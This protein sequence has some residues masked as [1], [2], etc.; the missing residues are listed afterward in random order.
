MSQELK[1]LLNVY[2]FSRDALH[3]HVH[4]MPADEISRL[5][6]LQ[7]RTFREILAYKSEHPS[8]T[9]A[10]IRLAMEHIGEMSADTREGATMREASQVQ[11]ARLEQ[12]L[13]DKQRVRAKAEFA[14]LRA[15]DALSDRVA[16]IDRGYRYVFTN[17]ANLDFHCETLKTFEQRP[18]W[19]MTGERFFR[20]ANKPRFDACFTGK[21]AH[22]YSMRPGGQVFSTSYSPI[23]DPDGEI[24]SIIL[25]SRDATGLPI[26]PELIT[27]IDLAVPVN[28]RP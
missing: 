27:P 19:D 7:A 6:H 12:M 1:G 4:H 13:L 16:I 14:D 3:R 26:P 5:K 11:A 18:S 2:A 25:V 9:L 20:V 21:T 28:P 24:R 8:V 17:K 15:F 22:G 23:R 10:Q